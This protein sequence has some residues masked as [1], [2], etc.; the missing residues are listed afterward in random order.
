MCTPSCMFRT[1][2]SCV[3]LHCG[4]NACQ[5][6]TTHLYVVCCAR[7]HQHVTTHA[8]MHRTEVST[9]DNNPLRADPDVKK[10][11]CQLMKE[12]RSFAYTRAFF[13]N[14]KYA[15]RGHSAPPRSRS[16]ALLLSLAI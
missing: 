1:E 5:H 10:Y 7:R 11:A 16:C 6:V 14:S 9:R 8:C 4:I 3:A 12:T 2:L 13:E 15:T